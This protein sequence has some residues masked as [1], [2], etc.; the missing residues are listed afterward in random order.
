MSA[1]EGIRVVDLTRILAGPTCTQILGDLG[2]DVI[3]IEMPGAGDDTRKWAPPRLTN[4]KGE[5]TDES[6]YFQN[7]NR[8][9]R[10]LTVDIRSEKGQQLLLSL[11]E[12][13]DVLVE[14]FK[15][16]GL[17]K[18]GLDYDS[19]KTRFPKLVYCSI[20]GFGQTGPYA[21]RPGYDVLI[22]AMGGLMSVTGEPDGEPQKCGVPFSDLMAGMYASVSICAALRKRDMKGEEGEGQQIDIGML[23]TT[24]AMLTNQ[25]LNYLTSGQVPPR[26]GNEHPNITPYQVFPTADGNVIIACGNEQ[27]WQR[28]C[29]V[30]ERPDLLVDPRFTTNAERLAHRSELVA[31]LNP[32]LSSKPS[33]H[34]LPLIEAQSISCGP[35]NDLEQVFNDPQVKARGMRLEMPHPALGN[36][37]VSLL[38]SPIRLS[39]TPV[40]YRHAPPLLGQHTDEVLNDVLGL[41]ADEVGQLRRDG[42]I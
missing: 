33:S 8:N 38:A 31:E 1:L 32:V 30:I 4:D 13:S 27:Q 18:Y 7:A 16:G 17:Q 37:P 35:I 5:E 15:F 14:N 42:V 11:I 10:S 34:W 26:L 21:P 41:S 9:K 28:F 40:E 24:V 29:G 39:G 12:K 20:T 22:Q 2:A 23:D 19:L 36:K 6:A 3:K 25:G